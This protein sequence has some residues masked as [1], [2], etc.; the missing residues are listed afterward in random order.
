MGNID[1]FPIGAEPT[2]QAIA[3]SLATNPTILIP[4]LSKQLPIHLLAYNNMSSNLTKSQAA[5]LF[6]RFTGHIWLILGFIM[7]K[8]ILSL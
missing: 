8:W 4:Q 5:E 1:S 7:E 3:N 2:W 6:I